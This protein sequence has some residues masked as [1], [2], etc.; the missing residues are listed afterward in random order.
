[1]ISNSSIQVQWD[2]PTHPNGILTY[3]DV[4]V[5]NNLTNFSISAQIG[6]ISDTREV[7]VRGMGKFNMMIITEY[8]KSA[9]NNFHFIVQNHSLLTL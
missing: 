1:M 2:P 4:I 6:A 5:F 7:T 8:S 9:Y 3:Y